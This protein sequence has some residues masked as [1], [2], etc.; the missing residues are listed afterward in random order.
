MFVFLNSLNDVFIVCHTLC[1][2]G[3]LTV[4]QAKYATNRCY[5][6]SPAYSESNHACYK[7]NIWC[8]LSMTYN[9]LF[10]NAVVEFSLCNNNTVIKQINVNVS[11]H[12]DT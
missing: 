9:K 7:H 8:T 1:I 11:S 6:H 2:R 3:S 4:K 10:Q 12:V 5:N